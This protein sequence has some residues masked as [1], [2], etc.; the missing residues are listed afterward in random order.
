MAPSGTKRRLRG[1]TPLPIF[2]SGVE[3][4]KFKGISFLILVP[5]MKNK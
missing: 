4:V 2:L 1:L 5:K 3:Q